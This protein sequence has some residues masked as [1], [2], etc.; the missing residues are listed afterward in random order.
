MKKIGLVTLYN[1]D[2]YGAL[3]QAY[4]LQTTIRN[5]GCECEI[6]QHDRFGGGIDHSRKTR[7]DKLNNIIQYL[8]LFL[9]NPRILSYSWRAWDK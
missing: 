8:S 9:R 3:L 6:V 1:S 2:N 5:L 4:A 7:R